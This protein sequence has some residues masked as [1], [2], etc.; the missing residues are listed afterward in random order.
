MIRFAIVEDDPD[1]QRTILAYL[2]DYF[3]GREETACT[4]F[5]DGTDFLAARPGDIDVIFLDIMMPNSNGIDV[6]RAIRQDDSKVII[7]FVTEATQY[8]LDGYG[9]AATD[10]LVKPLYYTSFCASMERVLA[11]LERRCAAMLQVN[12]DKTTSYLDV[13]TIFYLETKNK[14]VLIH[15]QSGDYMCS[16]TMR[17]LEAK[18]SPFGFGRCHQAYIVNT[19]YVES[20]TKTDLLVH[21]EHIPLSRNRREEFVA[22]LLKEVGATL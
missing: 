12:F 5:D 14:A 20:V 9:V 18:L 21:G 4:T 17:E 6:A 1:C 15:A 8:A 22:L 16:D 10:F 19:A 2:H 13:G 11:L 7:V 3:A